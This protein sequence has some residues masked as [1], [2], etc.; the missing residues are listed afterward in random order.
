[1]TSPDSTTYLVSNGQDV[2]G[3]ALSV[4][5]DRGGIVAAAASL[6]PQPGE[7]ELDARGG[8]IL[9][10]LRDHHLHLFAAA[11]ARR[12]LHCGPPQVNNAAD[13]REALG[14]HCAVNRDWVRGVGFHDSVCPDLNRH[15][16]DAVCAD[17]PVRV[18]HRSGMMWVLNSAAIEALSIDAGD[19]LPLGAERDGSGALTGRF[20]DCDDWLGQ[21]IPRSALSLTSLSRDLA[22][23]GIS[24]VTETGVNNGLSQWQ[25]LRDAVVSGQFKQRLLVMG[26]ESLNGVEDAIPGRIEVGPLKLYLREAALPDMA[27]FTRRIAEAHRYQRCIAVHCVTRVE[28]HFALAALEEAGALPGDRIEH[29]SVTDDYAMDKLAT[30]G[31]TAVTQP[32]F[33]AERGDQYLRDVDADD[34]PLLYRGAGFLDRGVALA[35]GSDAPYGDI[36]PWAGMAAAINRRSR[37]GQVLQAGEAIDPEQAASLYSGLLRKPGGGLTV[38]SGMEADLCVLDAPWQ[39]CRQDLRRDHVVATFSSGQL[40]YHRDNQQ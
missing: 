21:R 34:I 15:W 27:E 1:M 31:V 23:L 35:A 3:N 26:N 33:I 32:H 39:Q 40:I 18:Q 30:L 22:R 13:L 24:A 29:A 38:Q 5:L 8:V 36:D 10:G 7:P 20:Y 17:V 19:A 2:D 11:S 4:R 16:L 12:S 6:H 37:S 25:S 28:L 9:P 14:Q